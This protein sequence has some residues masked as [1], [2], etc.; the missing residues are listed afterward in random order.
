MQ[1]TGLNRLEI[2]PTELCN[3]TCSFCPRSIPELYPNRN[4]HMS[5]DT[6]NLLKDQLNDS[7][8]KGWI[9]I[10]GRGEPFLHKNISSLVSVFKDFKVEIISNGDRIREGKVNLDRLIQSGLDK[11]IL[12][13]YDGDEQ[14]KETEI[15]LK[16]YTSKLEVIIRNRPDTGEEDIRDKLGMSNRA[17]FFSKVKP[18]SRPC[19]LPMYKGFVDWNGDVLLCCNDWLKLEK[20]YGNIHETHFKDLWKSSRYNNIRK[21]LLKGDRYKHKACAGCDTDGCK[22]GQKEADLWSNY[23]V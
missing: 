16:P 7:N 3:R 8:Y 12:D 9:G 14:Y 2:N 19:F 17:G 21:D 23:L 15:L 10:I 4:L 6:A 18:I 22:T 5:L 11:L 20:S 13:C 1:L